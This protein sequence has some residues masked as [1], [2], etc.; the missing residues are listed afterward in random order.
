VGVTRQISDAGLALIKQAEGLRLRAYRDGG[1]VWTLGYGHTHDVHE[2]DEI[3]EHQA[4]VMLRSDIACAEECVDLRA[5]ALNQNQFD[6]C[7][8]LSFNIGC[9]RFDTSTLLR[10]IRKG[11]FRSAAAQFEVWNKDNG[12]VIDGLTKRRKRERALFE[13]PMAADF[14]N[15]EAGVETTAPKVNP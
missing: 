2:G 13:T 10:M 12:K 9:K 8:S 15:I 4:E 11:D 6:A 14:S 3:T 1:G 5:P 7:V